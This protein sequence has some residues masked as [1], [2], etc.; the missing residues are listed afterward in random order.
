MRENVRDWIKAYKKLNIYHFGLVRHS[1]NI[2]L[3]T[4]F[5]V[6]KKRRL[7]EIKKDMWRI[8]LQILQLIF[9]IMRRC[10]MDSLIQL[11]PQ[12]KLWIVFAKLFQNHKSLQ[13]HLKL[14]QSTRKLN[15]LISCKYLNFLIIFIYWLVEVP[16]GIVLW[17]FLWVCSNWNM[18]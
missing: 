14:S 15:S 1:L 16:M 12:K 9:I 18:E 3:R 13:V 5:L 2:V 8:F 7:L 10:S 4:L 6:N 11:I 17:K